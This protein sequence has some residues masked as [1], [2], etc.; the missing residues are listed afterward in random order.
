MNFNTQFLHEFAVQS[1]LGSLAGFHFA[2]RKL[3]H[4]RK[5]WRSRAPGYQQAGG[6][7]QRVDDG[8]PHDIYQCSHRNSLWWRDQWAS[9]HQDAKSPTWD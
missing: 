6:S 2:A 5:L 1:G 7:F 4:A 9:S 8:G 3:P